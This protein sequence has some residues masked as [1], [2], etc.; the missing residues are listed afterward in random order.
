MATAL[1]S[2][3]APGLPSPAAAPSHVHPTHTP[4]ASA[5]THGPRLEEHLKDVHGYTTTH[6]AHAPA[7]ATVHADARAT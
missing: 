7:A 3:S 4:H 2:T 1:W 5:T 6:A